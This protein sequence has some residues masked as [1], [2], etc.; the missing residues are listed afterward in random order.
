MASMQQFSRVIMALLAFSVL[1]S[2]SP[3]TFVLIVSGTINALTVSARD[4]GTWPFGWGTEEIYATEFS[5]IE[6]ARNV[7][8]MTR[9]P[10]NGPGCRSEDQHDPF[11]FVITRPPPCWQ[12]NHPGARIV[13]G[14]IYQ[15]IADGSIRYGSG[16]FRIE[17]GRPVNLDWQG[18]PID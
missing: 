3:P 8:K 18:N 17:N 14:V 16:Y 5:I 13:P 11:P 1:T 10:I 12:Q 7:W 2:C 4:E 6:G 15:V 9:Q